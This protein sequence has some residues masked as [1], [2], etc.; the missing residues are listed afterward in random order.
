VAR[1]KARVRSVL[2][3]ALTREDLDFAIGA[4]QKVG[5]ELGLLKGSAA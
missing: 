2:K 5:A 3:A 1:N 4:F